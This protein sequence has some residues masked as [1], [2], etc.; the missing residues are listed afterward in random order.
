M[1]GFYNRF[2]LTPSVDLLPYPEAPIQ[3]EMIDRH[4]LTLL[5]EGIDIID[6]IY[7]GA[8]NNQSPFFHQIDM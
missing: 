3:R 1:P 4:I 8:K 6:M 2:N 7:T 5:S